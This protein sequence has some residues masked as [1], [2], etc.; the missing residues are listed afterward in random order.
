MD[1]LWLLAG[2]LLGSTPTGYLVVKVMRGEDIRN[3][4]SGNIGATNVG[5]VMGKP[6]AVA[7]AVFDMLKGGLAVGLARIAGIDDA[8][9]LALVG[10][11]GVLGHN[12][13][14]WLRFKGG[15]GVATSFGVL[16]FFHPAA[17]VLGG[18]VWYVT[19]R[20]TRYVSVASMFSLATAPIWLIIVAAPLPFVMVAV[21]FDLLTIMRHRTNV[22]R[23]L[24]GTETRVG[25]GKEELPAEPDPV[26]DPEPERQQESPVAV[27]E[28]VVVEEVVPVIPAEPDEMEDFLPA[29]SECP[30]AVELEIVVAVAED[31]K[32]PKPAPRKRRKR[33]APV[34]KEESPAVSME[35]KLTDDGGNG[36]VV[37]ASLAAPEVAEKESEKPNPAPR[38]RRKSKAP[39]PEGE[40][41]AARKETKAAEGIEGEP[42]V[43]DSEKVPGKPRPVPR[44]RRKREPLS[45]ES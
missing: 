11:F 30:D 12:F 35:M 33:K 29:W 28:T 24:A 23:L 3:V 8:L 13:P 31:V 4:G 14:V 10:L 41:P 37:A 17:A 2:Y 27:L 39:V 16:F 34:P 7:V 6:W 43:A 40:S 45:T 44:K 5:R 1:W 38:K 9:V 22:G 15:K 36:K 18:L 21:L 42:V 32:T 20:V 19:M 26:P 25:S